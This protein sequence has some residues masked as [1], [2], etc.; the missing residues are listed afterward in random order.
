MADAWHKT[1]ELSAETT[2]D[3]KETWTEAQ[4]S[5]YQQLGC[6]PMVLWANGID[7]KA[8]NGHD[9]A[10]QLATEPESPQRQSNQRTGARN[11]VSRSSVS[12]GERMCGGATRG[13][14]GNGVGRS[15]I[16]WLCGKQDPRP[17]GR[18]FEFD[19]PRR[20]I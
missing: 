11:T 16:P 5:L 10:A 6:Q 15:E 7:H 14:M 4:A 13:R 19:W 9:S 3:G 20:R 17:N 18:G 12:A 2:L 8:Q 1:I